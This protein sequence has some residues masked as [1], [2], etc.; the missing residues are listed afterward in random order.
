MRLGW[1]AVRQKFA[2]YDKRN[3]LM[4][5]QLEEFIVA[6]KNTAGTISKKDGAYE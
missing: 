6:T 1:I 5:W 4:S 3:C 2:F